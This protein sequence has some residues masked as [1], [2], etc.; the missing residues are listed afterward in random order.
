MHFG[1]TNAKGVPKYCPRSLHLV[2]PNLSSLSDGR[3]VGCLAWFLTGSLVPRPP[4]LPSPGA[5]S[6]Y[7]N[8]AWPCRRTSTWGLQGPTGEVRLAIYGVWNRLSLPAH[9][10]SR[11]CF[12]WKAAP[13]WNPLPGRQ[14]ALPQVLA[15]FMGRRG[16]AEAGRDLLRR[17]PFHQ[18]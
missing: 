18:K 14:A 7:A 5:K 1:T 8:P 11:W 4:D 2:S 17:G 15:E 6:G 9:D 13:M 12:P 3:Q 16:G 10:L